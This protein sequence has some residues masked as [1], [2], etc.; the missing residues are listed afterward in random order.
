MDGKD[1]RERWAETIAMR[2]ADT[3]TDRRTKNPV[4]SASADCGVSGHAWRLY[5]G[6]ARTFVKTS[7]PAAV[8]A[9]SVENIGTENLIGSLMPLRYKLHAYFVL[10]KRIVSV[11]PWS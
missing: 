11:S 9:A 6:R 4:Q 10:S 5:L 2:G 3:R 8:A 1:G 7:I